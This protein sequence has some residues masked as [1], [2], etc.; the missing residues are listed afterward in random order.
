[1]VL[2]RVQGTELMSAE[3]GPNESDQLFLDA[4]TMARW[5][6]GFL[7]P[8]LEYPFSEALLSAEKLLSQPNRI[9]EF[10]KHAVLRICV[11]VQAQ[12]KIAQDRAKQARKTLIKPTAIGERA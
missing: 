2:S 7:L 5:I 9:R 1:M 3:D 6:N 12:R 4:G 8:R 11:Y 10:I